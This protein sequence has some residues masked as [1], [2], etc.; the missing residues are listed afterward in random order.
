MK[1]QIE[2]RIRAGYVTVFFLLGLSYI[3]FFIA[4]MRLTEHVGTVNHTT[5]AINKLE[6]LIS[7]VKDAETGV[8]GFIA[9]KDER[10]LD[11]YEGSFDQMKY[12]FN[13]LKS[14]LSDNKIQQSRLEALKT[15]INDKYRILRESVVM[16][17]SNGMQMTDSL[18]KMSYHGKEVMDTI[19]EMVKVMEATENNLLAERT[20]KMNNVL[21][22]L[23]IFIITSIVIASLL[24]VYS[25]ITYNKENSA[26]KI[27]DANALKYRFELEERIDELNTANRE[28]RELKSIEKF[29]ASGRIARQMAHE[30]RN[31]LTNIG[32]ASEQLRSELNGNEDHVLFFDMIDRNA[33]RIN[34]LVSDLLNSTKFAQLQV[35][36]VSIN[37]LLDEVLLDA[38]DR[39]E[40]K[41]IKL[42]KDYEEGMCMVSV[43]KERMKIALLNLIVNAIEAMEESKGVLKIGTSTVNKK[44]CIKISDNG[45]GISKEALGKLFEPY[46]TSKP[47]GT[48]LG[49]TATQNIV[50]NHNGLIDVE[51]EEGKGSTFIITLSFIENN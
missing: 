36:N 10:F 48:G 39:L 11:V 51:S 41:S 38:N 24:A 15:R 40:L 46:Y 29:A 49:L 5:A 1:L 26:K 2:N 33:K 32:L 7:Y 18:K 27:A 47:K 4:T 31:P 3:S 45:S 13:E 30:I 6:V 42:V 14:S 44:C 43:D 19:R 50:L 12:V 16:Y 22:T 8:R 9:V 37:D 17:K 20:A 25:W 23:N 28:L 35:E 34:Q 21:K